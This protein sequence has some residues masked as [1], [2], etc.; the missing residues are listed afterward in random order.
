M[1]KTRHSSLEDLLSNLLDRANRLVR[2]GVTTCEVK[3]GYGLTIESEVK[4]LKAIQM[5]KEQLSVS[6]ISTCLA[7]HAKISGIQYKFRISGIFNNSFIPH[8]KSQQVVKSN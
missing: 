4:M 8:F 5:A 6:L 3:S 7:A 1:N 2:L